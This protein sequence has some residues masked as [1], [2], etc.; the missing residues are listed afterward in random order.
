ML[1]ICATPIGNLKDISIRALDVLSTSDI[2]L[3]ED[4]RISKQ[5]LSAHGITYKK[6][7]ALHQH[8]ENEIAEKVLEYLEEG[9]VVTQI[10]D[11]GTPG[12]SDP[13]ARLCK[14][15]QDRGFKVSPIPGAC[16][17]TSLLSV[18]GLDKPSLF[19][20][21]LPS[22]ANAR[23]IILEQWRDVPYAVCIYEAPHRII[24]CI[25]NIITV[26]G[27]EC[28]VLMGRELTKQF[29]TIKKS[30]ATGLLDF[31]K[32]DSNQQRGEFVLLIYPKLVEAKLALEVLSGEQIRVLKLLLPE[33]PPKKAVTIAHK[34]TGANKDLLYS[35]AVESVRNI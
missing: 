20:G 10:S 1:Y 23:K 24:A 27:E 31:V 17:Y 5:L 34:L 7:I 9:L 35:Y 25:E 29:E 4:T 8:N 18:S 11:A 12:I 15:V 6:L 16:A 33:M 14:T 3:C 22:S 13:G 32:S 28:L 26:L 30:T 21:F 19:Y 2:I